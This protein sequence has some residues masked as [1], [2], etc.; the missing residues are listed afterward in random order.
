MICLRR[1]VCSGVR[2]RAVRVAARDT[3]FCAFV[4]FYVM[5]SPSYFRFLLFS[6]FWHCF[7]FCYV[8][9]VFYYA[10]HTRCANAMCGSCAND[11]DELMICRFHCVWEACVCVCPAFRDPSLPLIFCNY[12]MFLFTMLAVYVQACVC[13]CVCVCVT[14]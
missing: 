9:I 11:C 12:D 1:G 6:V 4:A 3:V 13:M 2:L 5:L 7:R 8:F 14:V 10:L